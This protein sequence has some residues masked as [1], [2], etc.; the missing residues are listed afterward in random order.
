MIL[1]D[2]K[3]DLKILFESFVV[4]IMLVVLFVLV[5]LGYNLIVPQSKLDIH[6]LVLLFITGALFHIL[7]EVSGINQWYVD[8]YYRV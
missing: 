5:R 2:V 1:S 6:I 7:C 4:G 3:K 8:T